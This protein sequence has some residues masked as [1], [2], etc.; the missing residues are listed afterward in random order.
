MLGMYKFKSNLYSKAGEM[1]KQSLVTGA[2]KQ[3]FQLL[4]AQVLLV[5]FHAAGNVP[6]LHLHRT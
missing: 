5:S 2:L 1:S 6:C 4:H 3:E